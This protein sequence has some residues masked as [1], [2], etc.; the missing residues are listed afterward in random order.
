M[1]DPAADLAAALAVASAAC[2]KPVPPRLVALGE[3]GL[4]GELRR[5]PGIDRRLSEAARLGSAEAVVPAEA[6]RLAGADHE[7][8]CRH[9]GAL[10]G[11]RGA[12]AGGPLAMTGISTSPT[13]GPNVTLVHPQATRLIRSA[14]GVG[15]VAT[16][17]QGPP[18][19]RISDA[20]GGSDC[21]VRP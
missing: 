13:P 17:R 18:P 11:D 2:N 21:G 16:A 14:E 19:F 6:R 5:V 3:V 12:S 10:G 4:A 1:S 8:S 20:D 15:L 9:G 7:G